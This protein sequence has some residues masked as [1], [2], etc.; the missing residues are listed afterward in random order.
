MVAAMDIMVGVAVTEADTVG[1]MVG[2]VATEAD[3]SVK[4]KYIRVPLKQSMTWTGALM[5]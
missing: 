1:D 4:K 2:V 3:V 5:N